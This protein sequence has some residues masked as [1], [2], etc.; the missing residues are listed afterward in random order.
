MCRILGRA[1]PHSLIFDVSLPMIITFK[2][3]PLNYQTNIL[4]F[5]CV[6]IDLFLDAFLPPKNG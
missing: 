1:H 3:Y 4:N 6:E 5:L 2:M